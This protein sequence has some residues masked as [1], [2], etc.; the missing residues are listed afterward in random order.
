VPDPSQLF[1]GD[2]RKGIPGSVVVPTLEGNRPL[3]VEL[4]VLTAKSFLPSPRRSAQGIDNG[5][6]S[7]LLAVLQQRCGLPVHDLDVYALAVGGVKLSEPGA[8]L[9]LGLATAS[10]I[11]GAALPPDLVAIGEVGLGGELRQ[12]AHTARRLD[13]AARLGFH[14]AVVPFSAP[15]PPAGIEAMRVGTLVDAIDRLGMLADRAGGPRS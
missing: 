13:E 10:S 7:L 9:G 6:L 11:T 12:V 3:L 4:Q 8:D 14:R 2:R 15:E 5:R 1:L